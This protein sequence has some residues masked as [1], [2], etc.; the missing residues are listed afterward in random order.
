MVNNSPKNNTNTYVTKTPYHQQMI[1]GIDE[2]GRGPVIGPLVVGIVQLPKDTDISTL[3]LRDSKTLT[4]QQRDR[5]TKK[6][7]TIAAQWDILVISAED[8]DTLRQTM[9]LNQLEVYAFSTVINK[10]KPNTC[11]VDSADVN[12]KRFAQNIQKNLRYTPIIISEH[13]ADVTYPI[14][15]AASIIAKTARDTIIQQIEEELSTHLSLPLG[16][17]Y[18]AD[19]ITKK[20][21]STWL[22]MY[23]TLPPHI[24]HSWKT[25]QNLLNKYKTKTLDKF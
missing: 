5:L 21:L 15:S 6:I 7:K 19:P 12:A 10:L 8:I 2:A 20:F 18:P 16:S 3:H 22:Q 11:Y 14:V 1:A 13:K 4:P 24:R 25:T 23:G 17:G 9:T